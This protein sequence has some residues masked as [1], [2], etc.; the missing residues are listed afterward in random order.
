MGRQRSYENAKRGDIPTI[1]FGRRVFGEHP[2]SVGE[3]LG[4][5]ITAADVER[6]KSIVETRKARVGGTVSGVVPPIFGTQVTTPVKSGTVTETEIW[7]IASHFIS[8]Y[9][10]RAA[11]VV[12]EVAEGMLAFGDRDALRGR[13]LR[14]SWRFGRSRVSSVA[15]MNPRIEAALTRVWRKLAHHAVPARAKSPD[16][17][18]TCCIKS[19]A[20]LPRIHCSDRSLRYRLHAEYLSNVYGLFCNKLLQNPRNTC[21]LIDIRGHQLRC[22]TEPRPLFV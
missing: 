21:R 19:I 1:K 14:S 12:K 8:G 17:T 5:S 13:G 7:R 10:E 2:A 15:L 16:V 3:E 20:L 9:G 4:R 6:A 18:T 22:V 11:A